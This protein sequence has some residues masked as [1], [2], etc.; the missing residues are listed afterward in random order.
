MVINYLA[1]R[2]LARFI[3]QRRTYSTSRRDLLVTSRRLVIAG[4]SGL[5]FTAGL[6]TRGKCDDGKS[7]SQEKTVVSETADWVHDLYVEQI[8]HSSLFRFGRAAYVVLSVFADYKSSLRNVTDEVEYAKLKS[9]CHLRSAIKFRDLCSANGGVFMKVGQHIG[10][11]EFLFPKEYTETLRI[12]QYEAPHSPM[13]DIKYVIESDTGKS[14]Y[15]LFESFDEKPLGAA[16]LAQ[17]HKAVLKDGKEVAV[18]IQHKTVKQHAFED[19]KVIE[20]FVRMA[21]KIFPEFQFQWL[22]DQ[23]KANL[24]LE[25]DFLNEGKN[26]EKMRDVLKDFTGIRVPEVYW[27]NSTHRVL[28]MEY[29][30]GGVVDDMKYINKHQMDVNDI[31]VKLGQLYSE[32]IY[33][34]GLIHCDPHPGNILIRKNKD[35]RQEVILLDHG[36]YLTMKDEVRLLY[37]KLWQSIIELNNEDIKKYSEA[38][39]CGEYYGL[40]TCI[41]TGRS[42]NAIQGGIANK[43]QT[44]EE[45]KEVQEGILEYVHVITEVFER[46]PREMILILKTNDLLR[47]LDARLKTKTASASFVTMSKCCLRALYQDERPKCKSFYSKVRIDCRYIYDMSRMMFFQAMMSPF[48]QTLRQYQHG[49]L[50]ILEQYYDRFMMTLSS[51]I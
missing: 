31:S 23:I 8:L 19:A 28:F 4:S 12:F 13:K 15:D 34:K 26:C 51:F 18:K 17:V 20:F 29:I 1:R 27:K 36:L 6:L 44:A 9:E 7:L 33:V 2:T 38:L 46:L 16:S 48:G 35:G 10:S 24:P 32:M 39:G 40:L 30:K 37:C 3:S 43:H 42:W 11:L 21:T 25:L 45:L 5:L 49:F 14:M 41:V 50:S 47:G 22:T